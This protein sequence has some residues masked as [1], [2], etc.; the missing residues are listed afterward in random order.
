[1]KDLRACITFKRTGVACGGKCTRTS[2]GT[3]ERVRT[4]RTCPLVVGVYGEMGRALTGKQVH[5][6]EAEAEAERREHLWA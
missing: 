3:S 6:R 1:M 4:P 5:L 2:S